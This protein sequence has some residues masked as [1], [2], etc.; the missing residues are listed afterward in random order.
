MLV[1]FY[2]RCVYS[3]A[4]AV[5]LAFLPSTHTP[6]QNASCMLVQTKIR[7]LLQWQVVRSVVGGLACGEN[8]FSEET[9][10]GTG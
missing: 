6:P 1:V 9:H 2:L 3:I 7:L 4:A 5:A 10:L 8:A